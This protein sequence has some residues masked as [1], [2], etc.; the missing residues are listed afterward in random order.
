M[1]LELKQQVMN[2]YRNGYENVTQKAKSHCFKVYR[3]Y[4]ISFN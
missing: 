3:A 4:S 1:K 2:K